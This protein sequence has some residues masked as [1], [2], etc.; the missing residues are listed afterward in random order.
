M[1]ELRESKGIM[2]KD[3][4]AKLNV[5]PAYLCMVEHGKRTPPPE[6]YKKMLKEYGSGLSQYLR[7]VTIQKVEKIEN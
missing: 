3:M 1:K 5:H 7:L 2:L 4:A 6:L